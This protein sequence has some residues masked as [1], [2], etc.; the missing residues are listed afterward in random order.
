MCAWGFHEQSTIATE[1]I[2]LED[3]YLPSPPWTCV[4]KKFRLCRWGA[5]RRVKR[6][7]TRE[8]GPPSALAEFLSTK[9]FCYSSRCKSKL[10]ENKACPSSTSYTP[11]T[12]L[13]NIP[14]SV[15]PTLLLFWGNC[16][17]HQKRWYEKNAQQ[18]L[19]HFI[20][21]TLASPNFVSYLWSAGYALLADNIK[22]WLQC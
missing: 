1:W 14:H 9:T 10:W 3:T 17:I 16:R 2:K 5:E 8:R 11:S 12:I 7:Q 20:N 15:H 19:F 6:A 21:L 18:S 13:G 22:Q 4:E